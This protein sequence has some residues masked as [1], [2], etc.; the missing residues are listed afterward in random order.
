MA[1][2]YTNPDGLVQHFG[3]RQPEDAPMVRAD[4]VG[5]QYLQVD[6]DYSDL[7]TA[8]TTFWTQDAGGGSTVDSPS[9]ANASIPIGAW[10]KSATLLVKDAFVGATAQL[11]IGL[12]EADGTV[13]D[14]DGIDAVIAVT[15]IDA[16]GDVVLCNGAMVANTAGA[17]TTTKVAYVG[18]DYDT[19]AFTAGSARLI[20]EY[21]PNRGAL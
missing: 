2:F 6:F 9:G 19:A 5:P 7:G 14:A 4:N 15:A 12:Y 1:T 17:N 3:V 16:A 13:I 10:I 18:A 20:I 21:F 8:A 11:N